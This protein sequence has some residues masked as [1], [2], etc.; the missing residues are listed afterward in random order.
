MQK[1]KHLGL[2]GLIIAAVAVGFITVNRPDD[3]PP[4]KSEMEN[5]KI[6]RQFQVMGI[7]RVPP[8]PTPGGIRLMDLVGNEIRLSDF[9]GKII[10]LNIWT[11][12]CPPCRKEMPAMEKLHQQLKDEKFIILA[13]SLKEAAIK[14]GAFFKNQKLT[15]PALL[16]P[17][18]KA[19][20]LLGVAQ[21]PTTF[22][23]SK[24][25]EFMGKALGPRRWGDK[26][27][28]D[29]FRQLSRMD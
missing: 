20:K 11:T 18:G 25:G 16:D 27:S 14:V 13:V 12:W 26:T 8:H 6:D 23:L 1:W 4:A 21:I 2:F 7:L 17:K 5:K 29:L 28:V 10:F 19:T 24:K 15:F 3:L 9:R 22:I